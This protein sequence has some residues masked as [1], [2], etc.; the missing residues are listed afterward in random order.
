VPRAFPLKGV[1]DLGTRLGKITP[2]T[3]AVLQGTPHYFVGREG[4]VERV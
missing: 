4:E 2:N 3:V 1:K